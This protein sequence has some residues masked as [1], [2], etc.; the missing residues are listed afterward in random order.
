MEIWQLFSV[1]LSWYDGKIQG[2]QVFKE[3]FISKESG[4]IK[5]SGFLFPAGDL[6]LDEV[7]N[8]VPAVFSGLNLHKM[9][10]AVGVQVD[11]F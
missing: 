1:S 9:V 4:C 7:R 11:A 6:C 2:R 8:G 10:R 5:A 3:M